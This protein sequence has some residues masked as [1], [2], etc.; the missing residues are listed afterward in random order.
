[1]KPGGAMSA[2][3][4]AAQAGIS[5][6]MESIAAASATALYGVL[7]AAPEAPGIGSLRTIG[8]LL[9]PEITHESSFVPN[10]ASTA[11][12]VN[13][14]EPCFSCSQDDSRGRK[15]LDWHPCLSGPIG[16]PQRPLELRLAAFLPL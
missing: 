12:G 7:R 8:T 4:G 9:T 11:T 10:Q 6:P 1:M 15:T 3:M 13:V 16:P 14:R 5:G 2:S